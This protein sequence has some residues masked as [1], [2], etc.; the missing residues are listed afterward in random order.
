[1]KRARKYYLGVTTITQDADDFLSSPYGRP[2]VTNSALQLLMKQAPSSIEAVGTA[3]ALT[4]NE[5]SLL[6]ETRVGEGLFFVGLKHVAIRI[7]ASFTEDQIITTS[8][9]QML[10]LKARGIQ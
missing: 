10:E 8:P 7:V 1:M 2:I 9:E 4:E 3:F 6:L 5:K